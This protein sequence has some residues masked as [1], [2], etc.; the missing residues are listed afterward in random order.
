[1]NPPQ[2]PK[3][4]STKST[5]PKE[6]SESNKVKTPKTMPKQTHDKTVKSKDTIENT[7]V[8]TPRQH[9]NNTEHDDKHKGVSAK[10]N[11]SAQSPLE[12]NPGKKTK[13]HQ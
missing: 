11:A 1:M 13:R 6:A 10:R 9:N 2:E 8:K 4:I 3:G 7:K 12:G 5:T